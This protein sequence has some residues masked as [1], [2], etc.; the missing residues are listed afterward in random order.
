MRNIGLL[1]V[2][3]TGCLDANDPPT[4]PEVDCTFDRSTPVTVSGTVLD[5]S[6]KTPVAGASVELNTA[7]NGTSGFPGPKACPAL[8]TLETGPDGRFGPIT[9]DV[10]SDRTDNFLLFLVEGADR[11]PTASDNRICTDATCVLDHTI[12]AP[13]LLVAA[14]WRIGL[15]AGGVMDA[16]SR[17]LV[18]FEYLEP[19]G[20][21][22]IGV[23][24]DYL[25][26][27]VT[28]LAPGAQ[29]RYL[30][31]DR[32]ALAPVNTA[33]TTASGVALIASQGEGSMV[34]GGHREGVGWQL[35]GCLHEAGW[36][37][38]EDRRAPATSRN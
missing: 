37:F 14:N 7:W 1:F 28:D 12:S 2:L 36:I 26:D 20:A 35:T 17:G 15:A 5:F 30:A 19:T 25:T 4:E 22:A 16:D 9:I 10:P 13:S 24:S 27:K 32:T 21:P 31:P 3:L 34:I 38:L 6:T 11:E 29:V 18:A 33:S 23:I 8:A